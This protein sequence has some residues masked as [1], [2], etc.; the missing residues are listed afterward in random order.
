MSNATEWLANLEWWKVMIAIAVLLVLRFVLLAIKSQA[1]K[2]LAEIAESLAIAMGLVFLIIRPF[3]VQAFFIPS[4]SMQPT[5]LGS[6]SL[7]IF[8]HIL[9]NKT[10]YRLRDPRPGEV[11]VFAAPPAALEHSGLAEGKQ[12]DFIKRVVGVPG[13][14]IYVQSSYLEVNG[15]KLGHWALRTIFGDMRQ[16]NSG[17]NYQ[18][19]VVSDRFS[20]E[21][22]DKATDRMIALLAQGVEPKRNQWSQPFVGDIPVMLSTVG[23]RVRLAE[24]GVYVEGR[25]LTD[26]ELRSRFPAGAKIIV[27]PGVVVRNGVVQDPPFVAEDA[28]NPYPVLDFDPGDPMGII[29]AQSLQQGV[30]DNKLKLIK[31]DGHLQV[32]LMPGEYLMMGDNRNDSSDGRY[33]GPLDRDRIKGRAL[34]I[35]FPF[36]RIRW[37]R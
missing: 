20:P 7:K 34:F 23:P 11:I 24:D 16:E 6:R 3:F 4:E 22:I 8:D 28:D 21:G 25:K 35:F 9:V 5:L 2:S 29:M 37:V 33:W 18:R 27:H 36:N 12:T 10:V 19:W 26:Q 1:T 15:K 31:K 14:E 30:K 32:K 17:S 13:D